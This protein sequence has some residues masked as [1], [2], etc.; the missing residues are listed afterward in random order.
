MRK[1]RAAFISTG[2]VELS[3]AKSLVVRDPYG[4]AVQLQQRP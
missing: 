1:A 2:V 4:H 3:G